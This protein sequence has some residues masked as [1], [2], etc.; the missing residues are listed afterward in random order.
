ME[1]RMD[2]TTKN[3]TKSLEDRVG[4]IELSIKTAKIWLGVIVALGA[5]I[6]GTAA[7]YL[8]RQYGLAIDEAQGI[9]TKM[10]N[11]LNVN[12]R[13]Q[14][15]DSGKEGCERILDFQICWG[16]SEE[17][18]DINGEKYKKFVFPA[19]FA[20]TPLITFG[21]TGHRYPNDDEYYKFVPFSQWA[22]KTEASINAEEAMA[23]K[24]SAPVTITYIA[25][26]KPGKENKP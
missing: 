23:S 16:Q 25:I 10:R 7:G 9:E 14:S 22:N 11:G 21:T 13:T 20:E 1:A 19:P 12:L 26:G 3:G 24:K 8:Y 2:E 17:I 18:A 5:V 15:G 4:Y 6:G